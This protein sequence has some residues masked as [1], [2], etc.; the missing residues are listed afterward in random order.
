MRF[1]KIISLTVGLFCFCHTAK[2]QDQNFN[3]NLLANWD[4]DTM[5]NSGSIVYNDCWG[6]VDCSGREYA[7]MGSA[8]YSHFFDLQDPTNP[9]E[10]GYFAGGATTIWRD[11]K[12]YKNYI[13]GV[14]DSCTEGLQVF[15]MTTAPDSVVRVLQTDEFF[16]KSHNIFLDTLNAKLYCPGTNTQS[17]GL[18]ILDLSETP[19]NPTLLSSIELPGGYVHDLYVRNDTA[20]CSHGFNGLYVYDMSDPLNPVTLGVLDNYPQNGYNHSSWL[21]VD[22]NHLI[23]ADETHNKALKIVSTDD[24]EDMEV[25]DLFRSTLL[26]PEDTASIVHNPFVLGD[27]VFLSYYHDGVQVYDFSDPTNAVKVASY[28]TET[29][30]TNYAGFK[31][32]WGVYPYLPSGTIIASD[33]QNGLFLFETEN[34]DMAPVT[35]YS[36]PTVSLDQVSAVSICEE[37]SLTINILGDAVETNWYFNDEQVATGTTLTV[38][39]PGAVY[40]IAANGHCISTTELIQVEEIIVPVS[41]P[42]FNLLDA[43][44]LGDTVTLEIEADYDLYQW[45]LNGELVEGNTENTLDIIEGATVSYTYG[46]EDCE[47][48]SEEFDILFED[49]PNLN[50]L[51]NGYFLTASDAGT[52]FQ[53]YLNGELIDGAIEQAYYAAVTGDYS[54][55]FTT[56]AGCEYTSE[57]LNIINST[58]E[59]NRIEIQL[60][61]NPVNQDQILLNSDEFHQLEFNILDLNGRSIHQGV[62]KEKEVSLGNLNAGIYVLQIKNKETLYYGRFTRI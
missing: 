20:Y 58:D 8:S 44:C 57:T 23:M 11:F 45:Y 17:N 43:Y 41:D 46:L 52:S 59:L 28:D 18:V 34:L 54:V 56:A 6:Y 27:L 2:S 21:S 47:K 30:N 36:S 12:S 25:T 26:A 50:I 51:I 3:L 19:E 33:V 24:L 10:I 53:W 4:I 49:Q 61:P 38:E 39:E 35:N 37:E 29:G 62:V 32:C 5:P 9:V 15:D 7:V 31:G 40:A 42:Q 60:Y 48:T 16:G 55:E 22:G 13:Y 14:C 1:Y